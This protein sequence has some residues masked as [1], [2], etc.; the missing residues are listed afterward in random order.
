VRVRRIAAPLAATARPQQARRNTPTMRAVWAGA[1]EKYERM[2]ALPIAKLKVA[3]R[4]KSPTWT[5]VSC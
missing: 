2:S 4:K 5:A 1:L 3:V